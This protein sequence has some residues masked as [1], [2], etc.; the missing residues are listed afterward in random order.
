MMALFFIVTYVHY[1]L[2]SLFNYIKKTQFN[3]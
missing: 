2:N 1:K 3:D